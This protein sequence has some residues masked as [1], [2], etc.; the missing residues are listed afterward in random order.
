LD[1]NSSDSSVRLVAGARKYA[2]EKSLL[3]DRHWL[4]I[5]ERNEYELFTLIY[6]CS[7]G[8]VPRYF[9]DHVALTSSV[10]R[11]SFLQSVETLT[12][13]VPRTLLLFGDRAFSVAGPRT[14]YKLPIN[15]HF[16]QSMFSFI[17]LLKTYLF[18]FMR[19][20]H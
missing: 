12:L 19:T 9:A 14:W 1:A 17:K 2:H 7:H 3:R 15:V 11:R 18:H 10:G 13:E 4:P 6:W 8:N 5:S 16:A 20:S